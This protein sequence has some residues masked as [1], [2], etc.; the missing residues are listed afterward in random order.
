MK[1]IALL[2]MKENSERIP[3]KN[4]RPLAGKPLFY[5]VVD[6]L[7]A[8]GV[9]EKLV[10][11]TDSEIIAELAKK[12][13]KDWVTIHERPEDLCGDYVSMY[14]INEY[15]LS[16]LGR[17]Y[18][19]LQT[20]STNPFLQKKTIKEAIN[21]Y[22]SIINSGEYDSLFSVNALKTRVYDHKLKPINHDPTKLIRTQDLEV[23]YEENSNL[24]LFGHDSF[25]STKQRLGE[26]PYPFP[27]KSDRIESLDIDDPK[28]WDF[29]ENLVKWKQ[30]SSF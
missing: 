4:Y 10:I 7:K 3:Q 28:D 14:K 27:M 8:T 6:T 24:Y 1:F 20:H 15:D 21:I 18:H 23:I 19:Y 5:Y 13:Y 2:P 29:A 11:N 26:K 22:K 12:R 25:F 16:I 30:S 9:F 17:G